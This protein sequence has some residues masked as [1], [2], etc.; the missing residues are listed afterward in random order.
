M[1]LPFL[2]L[3]ANSFG[4]IFTEMGRQPWTVFGLMTTAQAVS[5]G[6]STAEVLTS[7]IVLHPGVRRPRGRRG[8]AA[9]DLHPPGAEPGRAADADRRRRRRATARWP[10]RTEPRGANHHGTHHRLVH[11]HRRPV[12]RL[13]LPR[14]LRLRRRHAAAGARQGRHRAPGADQHHRPGLGRQR[15]LAARRRRRDVRRVPRVVRHPVQ[16]VLPAAAADPGRPDRPRRRLRVPRQARRRDL[17]AQLGPGHHRR[18]VRA[19]RCCG[20][21][22]SA[23][24]C[25]ACRSTPT[26]STPAASST[27]STPTRCWA[28]R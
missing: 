18:L 9:A 24:S 19:R 16:R 26:S 27:C 3:F 22:R 12:D 21:W 2:P 28:A 13:L 4:W 8:A 11:P 25:A 7:L 10:S 15:G 5:P 14:G 6:V 23:T 17:A 20:A 1:L